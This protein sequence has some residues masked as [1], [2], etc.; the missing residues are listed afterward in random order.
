MNILATL[1]LF[2]LFF[3]W[4]QNWWEKGCRVPVV[5]QRVKNSRHSVREDLGSI[6]GLAH[7]VKDPALPQADMAWTPRGCGCGAGQQLQL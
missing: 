4:F 3:T 5:T 7:W 1:C 2:C 6:P